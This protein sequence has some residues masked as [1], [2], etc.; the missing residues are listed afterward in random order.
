MADVVTARE[1]VLQ[2]L[3]PLAASDPVGSGLI[4]KA[5]PR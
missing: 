1:R 2:F 4:E 5:A 3:K